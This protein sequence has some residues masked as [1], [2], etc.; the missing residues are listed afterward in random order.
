M[1]RINVSVYILVDLDNNILGV[2]TAQK[3]AFEGLNKAVT[4]NPAKALRVLV[5][6]VDPEFPGIHDN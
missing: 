3:R 2:Y 1:G 5:L 4:K 6:T